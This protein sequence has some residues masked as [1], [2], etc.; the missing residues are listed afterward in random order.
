MWGDSGWGRLVRAG[1]QEL[2]RFD[3]QLVSAAGDL[4]RNRWKPEPPPTWVTFVPSLR[5]P[6][7]VADFAERL[8]TALGLPCED[9]VVRI[10]DTKPQKTMQNSSQQYRNMQKAFAVR[11]GVPPGPVLLVDNIVDSR[12][13]LTVVG[14][15]LREA[16]A[17]P[18][19]P[20][21]LTDTAGRSVQ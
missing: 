11:G 14:M 15:G 8:A 9:V 13:T 5:S 2:G 18:V 6:R 17:G 20:F 3:N 10:Q 1:K 19:F 21:A 16:G 7:L 4:I 12:W